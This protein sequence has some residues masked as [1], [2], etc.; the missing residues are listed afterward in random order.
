MNQDQLNYSLWN[1]YIWTVEKLVL[2]FLE[3]CD[4]SGSH[5][6]EIKVAAFWDLAPCDTACGNARWRLLQNMR[7]SYI[8]H[9]YHHHLIY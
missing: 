7:C 4:I 5:D 3:I 6:G 8:I 9:Y 2:M 1:S